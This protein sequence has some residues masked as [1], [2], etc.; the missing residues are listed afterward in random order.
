LV[1]PLIAMSRGQASGAGFADPP[2]CAPLVR[3]HRRRPVLQPHSRALPR[4][5][6]RPGAA[7]FA[8]SGQLLQA[9]RGDRAGTWVTPECY[10]A[11]LLGQTRRPAPGCCCAVVTASRCGVAHGSL[12]L[13]RRHLPGGRFWEGARGRLTA[14]AGARWRVSLAACQIS[15]TTA[16]PGAHLVPAPSYDA[17]G[18]HARSAPRYHAPAAAWALAVGASMRESPDDRCW[19]PR[20]APFPGCGCARHHHGPANRRT[21]SDH[22][23]SHGAND[24]RL[25]C[26][27]VSMDPQRPRHRASLSTSWTVVDRR[28]RVRDVAHA[29]GPRRGWE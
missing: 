6:R 5:Y 4:R 13:D 9:T 1:M 29:Y 17:K 7:R 2:A 12:F 28:H 18:G 24:T 20:I 10:I 23:P 22:A 11:V 15:T 19:H 3:P 25:P 26:V 16:P 21:R 14:C 27:G 8:R